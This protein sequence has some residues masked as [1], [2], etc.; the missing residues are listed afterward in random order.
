MSKL[1]NVLSKL[2]NLTKTA[3]TIKVV[4]S[5]VFITRLETKTDRC[6]VYLVP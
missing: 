3:N 6:Q 4:Q 1:K 5:L 2:Q